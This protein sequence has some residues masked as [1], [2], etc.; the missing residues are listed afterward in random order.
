MAVQSR[1]VLEPSA[2]DVVDA[3]STHPFLYELEPAEARKVL[4]DLQS[5]PSRSC[6]SRR[7]GSPSR[8][9]SGTP[10]VRD[11][12]AHRRRRSAAGHRLHARRRLDPGQRRHPRPAG[13]RAGRRRSRCAAVRRVPQLARGPLSG[14]DR[15][16]VRDR[17]VGVREGASQGL[18][19]KRIAVAGE[20]V[21]GNM[22][23][24]LSLMAK[25][26]GDVH[27]RADLDVLPG[28]RRGDGHRLLRRVR[29]GLLPD[30]QVDGV[31]LGRLH[32]RSRRSVPRSPPRPTAR[33]ASSSRAYRRRCCSSTRST[34]CATR[35]RPTPPS[36]AKP[37]WRSPLSAMTASC[38][39]SCCWTPCATPRPRAP[40][41]RKPPRSCATHSAPD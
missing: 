39:T 17:A 30:A 1:V 27:V 41:S 23:A 9:Q 22:A 24:A 15:A 21:G 4:E 40:R 14:R 37:V 34:R 25:E 38:T 16:G 12:Q 28:H 6:R 5:G 7:N 10:K 31:V 18:D 3:T 33:P 20:S 29:R 35:A 26:R 11:R 13:A 36:C 19:P 32:H 8:P 2:Q